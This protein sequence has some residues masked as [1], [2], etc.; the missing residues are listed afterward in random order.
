MQAR[1]GY[2]RDAKALR[3]YAGR[4]S[5][6]GLWRKVAS[7]LRR[8][9][10]AGLETALTL[11]YAAKDPDTPAWARST[12]YGALG[13]LIWPLDSV[14]DLTPY[15]GYTDDLGILTAAIAAVA[16]HIKEGHRAAARRQAARW[17]D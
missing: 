12:I 6:A 3:A 8:T 16:A 2:D 14:P 11:Y 5:E 9:G 4:Y 10:R 15:V 13:Y 1:S 7:L 17:L